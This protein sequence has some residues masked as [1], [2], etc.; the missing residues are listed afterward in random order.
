MKTEVNFRK[1][2]EKYVNAKSNKEKRLIRRKVHS[3][4]TGA[5]YGT[6]VAQ[7]K[8]FCKHAESD[9]KKPTWVGNVEDVNTGR[10]Y[11]VAVW[12]NGSHIR[13]EILKEREEGEHTLP[14]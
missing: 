7:G 1:L 11:P 10:L 8:L 6:L 5:K 12:N 14:F 4:G 2:M 3:S 9:S 13:L